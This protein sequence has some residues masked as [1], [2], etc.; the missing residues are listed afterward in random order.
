MYIKMIRY[1]LLCCAFWTVLPV[2][3]QEM[4]KVTGV[5]YENQKG[6]PLP[7]A[8]VILLNANSRMISGVTTN[9]DG[10][11]EIKYVAGTAQKIQFSFIGMKAVIETLES[12]KKYEIILKDENI[13]LE[14][15]VIKG[16]ARP[17]A[18]F[19]MLQKDRRDLG[20][21]VSSVDIKTLQTQSV[22]SIDQMLQGAVPGLQVT[23]NSGDPGAG[24]SIRIPGGIFAHRTERSFMDH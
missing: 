17:K 24:A 2:S 16:T 18:D 19:G 23:F 21:A 15:V 3:A 13:G 22:S 12:G 10:T 6:T 1:L 4:E 9:A 7:G 5:V 8:N 20:N 11:F 14:E